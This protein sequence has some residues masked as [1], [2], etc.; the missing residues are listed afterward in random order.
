[1]A[2]ER[3]S[4][5]QQAC[6][7]AL[8]AEFFAERWTPL[9]LREIVLIGRRRFG[10]IHEALPRLSQS[11]LVERLRTLEQF[12]VIERRPNPAG[13]GYEYHPTSAGHDLLGV[14]D[15]LGS[16]AQRWIELRREDCDP[17]YVMQSIHLLLKADR[18]PPSV[19]VARIDL[20]PD[21]RT[22]WL[23][24]DPQAP[25]LCF[26][27][28][29]RDVEMV[30]TADVEALT[31]V[32][33]GRLELGTAMASGLVRLEGRSDLVRSFPQWLGLSRY[34]P[35]ARSTQETRDLIGAGASGS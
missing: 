15:S 7:I 8:A 10:E 6:P 27:D 11:L 32:I 28:P 30:V 14:L 18:L 9:I 31:A 23:V 34:A 24:L 22:Y 19:A 20:Q 33:L 17:A 13:R 35:F 3:A 25:E 26:H 29:G 21:A 1:M 4:L 16:W 5:Y 12:G 2:T